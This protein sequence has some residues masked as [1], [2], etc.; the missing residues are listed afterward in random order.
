MSRLQRG[1]LTVLAAC[2]LAIAPVGMAIAAP[3]STTDITTGNGQGV[4]CSSGSSASQS[5]VCTDHGNTA[6]PL[7]GCVQTTGGTTGCGSGIIYKAI[8]IITFAAGAAAVII[9]II[10]ALRFVTSGSDISTSS[11]TDTDVENARR[12]IAAAVIGLVIIVLARFLI[13]FVVGKL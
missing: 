12:T 6:N 4:D 1:V 8:N 2:M 10:G 3:T 5:A 9:L 7:T 13:L 11:R